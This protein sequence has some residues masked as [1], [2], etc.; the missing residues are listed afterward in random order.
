MKE[1][2]IKTEKICKSFVTDGEVNN[3]IKNMD[4]ELYQEDFTVIM[5]NSGSGKST[6]LYLLSG[7]DKVTSGEVYLKEKNITNCKEN[8][9]ASIRQDNIG[10]VFQ[11]MNLIPDLTVRE[12]VMS[13]TYRKKK[14]RKD[15]SGRV[16]ELL[17]Q[18]GM[19]SHEN[20]FPSQLSGG[21]RQR[22]AICRALMNEP[23]L[24]F[25]DE[26]TG[27]LNSGTGEMVLDLFTQLYNEG[28]SIVMVTHDLKAAVRGNRVVF[29]RDGRIDGELMLG[30][31]MKEEEK[32]REKVLFEFLKERGW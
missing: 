28:Q 10:F 31:F 29:L 2:I 14:A 1:C 18:M 32:N 30:N 27:A 25:A 13:P 16:N 8:E 7:M 3:V 6:L 12:N 17:L 9:M 19:Q 21:Q 4:L 15:W 11:G 24:I 26:P 5:G 20:K 23:E 22:T